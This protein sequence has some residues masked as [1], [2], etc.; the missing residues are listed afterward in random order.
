M[1]NF[2]FYIFMTVMMVLFY[3]EPDLWDSGMAYLDAQ[4]KCAALGNKGGA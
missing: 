4:T 1:S 2:G 3:G